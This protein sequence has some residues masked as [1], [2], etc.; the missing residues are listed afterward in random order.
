M[1]QLLN[2]IASV[3]GVPEQFQVSFCSINYK[4]SYY[5]ISLKKYPFKKAFKPVRPQSKPS[6]KI[7]NEYRNITRPGP[8]IKH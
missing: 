2:N 3:K 5:Y 4:S 1:S 8:L 6:D 7:I